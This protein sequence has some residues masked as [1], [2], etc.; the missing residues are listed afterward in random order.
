[1]ASGSADITIAARLATLEEARKNQDIVMTRFFD[2]TWI[3]MEKT[4][5]DVSQQLAEAKVDRSEMKV[6]LTGLE[7][8]IKNLPTKEST[9]QA[10]IKITSNTSNIEKVRELTEAN[11]KTL[12]SWK[13]KGT[14]IGFGIIALITIGFNLLGEG[15][16]KW[17]GLK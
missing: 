1:M 6:T 10:I 12:N 7:E 3:S 2:V 9:E 15:L 5:K 8:K 13:S 17:V 11:E 4:F 14:V 16:K